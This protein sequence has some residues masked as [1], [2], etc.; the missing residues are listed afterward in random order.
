MKNSRKL[1][2]VMLM[3]QI[4]CAPIGV[5]FAGLTDC[6]MDTMSQQSVKTELELMML[7]SVRAASDAEAIRAREGNFV[8]MTNF[9]REC[10]LP[11]DFVKMKSGIPIMVDAMEGCEGAYKQIPYF[12]AID[13]KYVHGGAF[14]PEANVVNTNIIEFVT[15]ANLIAEKGCFEYN[16]KHGFVMYRHSLPVRAV[17]SGGK[18]V[19]GMIVLFPVMEMDLFSEAYKAVLEGD[20]SPKDAIDMVARRLEVIGEADQN[21]RER[22]SEV[23][24]AA[25]RKFFEGNGHSAQAIKTGDRVRFIG[26]STDGHK[27]GLKND[28][29]SFRI[30]VG[31]DAVYSYVKLPN[32]ASN[33][34]AQ[35]CTFVSRMNNELIDSC[36]VLLFDCR[37]GLIVCR[38]QILVD[39]FMK[40]VPQ[41]ISRL[42]RHPIDILDTC[43][44]SID[45]ITSGKVDG[46]T[47]V[48]KFRDMCAAK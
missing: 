47:A 45:L 36:N 38:S 39:E 13:D 12:L 27:E 32:V 10:K 48:K 7:R 42:L 40:D 28:K 43:S 1:S 35:V 31:A 19:L 33:Y 5:S 8:F 29:Y 9:L 17:I 16:S 11:H 34:Q 37:N 22:H 41:S 25:I 4:A 2:H 3:A 15:R 21:G 24:V 20:K 30:E 26:S 23:A 44:N 46:E 14:F 18:K 6:E